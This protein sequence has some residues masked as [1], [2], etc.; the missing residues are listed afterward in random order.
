LS[1]KFV[2]ARRGPRDSVIYT[3]AD[4]KE[5]RYSAGDLSWRMN[6]PGDLWSGPVSKRNGEI[7]KYGHFAVFPDYESGHAALLDSLGTT[8]WNKNLAEMIMGYAPKTENNTN[9]YLQFLR[10][11]TGVKDDRK[12]RDFTSREFEKLWRAIEQYEG[13]HAGK[14]EAV[15]IRSKIT[16][17]RKNKKGTII[18]YYIDGIGWVSKAQGIVLARKGKV[19][20]VVATSRSGKPFLRTRPGTPVEVQLDHL[21]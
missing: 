21:G 4:G 20:A 3:A 5:F 10:S 17:V 9:Q 13:G 8:Y 1:A 18:A 12:I 14:I 7:G 19:D 15:Q 6:N 11:K 16:A 2:R